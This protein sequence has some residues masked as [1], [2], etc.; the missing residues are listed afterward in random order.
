MKAVIGIIGLAINIGVG[1]WIASIKNRP[2]WLGAVL[3]FLLSFIGWIILAVLPKK[4]PATGD[5]VS[6][7]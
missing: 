4:E 7:T 5:T 1:V 6:T 3:G 2:A